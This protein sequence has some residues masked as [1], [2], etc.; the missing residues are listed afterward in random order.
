MVLCAGL[1][2][3][4]PQLQSCGTHSLRA[5]EE[6]QLHHGGTNGGKRLRRSAAAS[7]AARPDVGNVALLD[8]SDGVVVRRN[9]FNLDQTTLR[10]TPTA[11]GKYRYDAAATSYD[12]A[13]ATAGI[14]VD[15]LG[16][17]DSRETPLPFAF[18]FFGVQY[19]SVFVNSDGNL[20]FVTSDADATDR[21]LGRF[22]SGQPRIAP[23]FTD[24]DPTKS[25][26]GVRVLSEGGRFVVSWSAVPIFSDSGSAAP[27]TFQARLY[28]DGRIEFAYS[29]VNVA[30]AVVGISPGRLLGTPAFVSFTH[31]PS[32]EYS[33]A[34]V[35]R[36]AGSEQVDIFTAAQKFYQTHEDAYDY[37][38]FYNALG[39]RADQDV[40]AF[41]VTVRNNRK[42]Y[43][44]PP[45][46]LGFESGSKER[47]QAILNMGQ[48]TQ[49]P[50]DPAAR[51]PARATVGDTPVTTVAHEAGHLFLAYVSV[52]DERGNLPMLGYQSAH[53]AFTF[54]S[55]A[56]LLEGNRIQDNGTAANPRFL[57]TATVEGYAPLDQYLMGFRPPQEVPDTFYVANARGVPSGVPARVGVGFNGDRRNVSVGDVIAE[58]GR[59]TPDSTVAQRK[60]RFAFVLITAEGQQPTTT[61]LA[62]LEGY[63]TAFETFYAKAATNNAAAETQLT[64]ALHVS[65]FPAAGVA[66]G[67]TGRGMVS[68]ESAAAAPITVLLNS[69]TGGV[70]IARSVTIPAGATTASFDFAGVRQGVD[71]FSASVSDPGYATVTSRIQVAAPSDLRLQLVSG[72]AQPAVSGTML[73]QPVRVRVTDINE[74][75]YPNVTLS[76]AITGGGSIQSGPIITGI[77]GIAEIR[78]TPS[79]DPV[80]ELRLTLPSGAA[81][82][83]TA[84]GRPSFSGTSVVNAASFTPGLSAGGIA[85]IFGASLSGARV[86]INGRA[87]QVFFSNARQI[88]FY[89]PLDT[90]TTP[91]QVS[92]QTVAGTSDTI[93]VMVAGAQ[94]GIFF[95]SGSGYGAITVAGTGTVTQVRPGLRGEVL[96][97]YTTGLGSVTPDAVGLSRTTVVPQVT[98]S[99]RPAEVLFSGLAPGFTGLYQVNVRVPVDVLPGT[100]TLDPE[101]EWTAF[102]RRES[103]GAVTAIA[104]FWSAVL[105]LLVQ[106]ILTKAILPW[107]GGTAGVWTSSMLFYQCMLLGGYFYAHLLSTRFSL[108]RQAQIHLA[109]LLLS[110]LLLPLRPSDGW[111]PDGVADPLPQIL[112]LLFSTVGLPYFLLSATSPLVQ[113][114]YARLHDGRTPYRLFSVS[115]LGSL[116]ALLSY[117]VA[118]EPFLPTH[119]Q[120]RGWSI[121]YAVFLL[122]ISGLCL[123]AMRSTAPLDA[124][125]RS[126]PQH[127][128]LWFSLAAAP[129]VLWLALANHLSQDIAAVP[130]LWIL[131]LSIYLLSFILCFDSDRWYQPR[132]YRWLLPPCVI[133]LLFGVGLQQFLPFTGF[134]ALY[135]F[136]LFI[137]CMFCH[138]ELARRKPEPSGLT[139][140]Y[141]SMSAGGAFGG[142]FV[143]LIAPRIF[144][145]YLELPLAGLAVIVLS[146]GTLYS[147]SRS[148]VLRVGG[149]AAAA[150]VASFLVDGDAMD[151]QHNL[152]NFY[153]T[154]QVRQFGTLDDSKRTLNNGAIQHGAQFLMGERRHEPTTYYARNSGAGLTIEALRHPG[155]RVGV[156]GLGVG[157]L[158]AYAQKGDYYRFYEINPLVVH[159]AKADFGYLQDSPSM[160]D[161]ALGD[162]RL[163]LEREEPEN[164]DVLLIDAFSGDSIPIHLLTLQAI[165]LYF[166]HLQPNGALAV[167]ITNKHLDLEPVLRYSAAARGLFGFLI[168]NPRAEDKGIT[169]AD[170]VIL[171]RNPQL[172]ERLRPFALPLKPKY[173]QWTDDYSNLVRLLR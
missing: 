161:I 170:W 151:Q 51:V 160:P 2:H 24:L 86:T 120:L 140:F 167:H 53:W 20:T 76:T 1:L 95:D 101:R 132:I 64:R 66:V 111:K 110:A 12:E 91:A 17:D 26:S 114:W 35:E 15:K 139:A 157:T 67:S 134:L 162:A 41:E 104:V 77:D 57:T 94:P 166:R 109:L 138:G 10:F 136:E 130:F 32:N 71:E 165:D 171:T 141:L 48:L 154:L 172:L 42:G 124:Q 13:A 89:V 147:L 90:P 18:P 44:D 19:R 43:G 143:G 115:N 33:S 158:A 74:I 31:Q 126:W 121:G 23:L 60:F 133:G 145:I 119:L 11:G 73:A 125:S 129:S 127:A 84:L 3:A 27:Q 37:L 39:I 155:M 100:Q 29:G 112:G 70:Q 149:T 58:A 4:R 63:R 152:R 59:R 25:T 159:L 98:I 168:H 83:A 75:P 103:R 92:V 169:N 79:S 146:L 38:V 117:P 82:T 49:Y 122:A 45:V 106:P 164:F 65:T 46:D 105:L 108:K 144:N 107:F 62:Q 68:V 148:R 173:Q 40:V 72:D 14:V 69:Q 36:F 61:Q 113:S 52:K 150:V 85:T 97:V 80:N 153:G 16:D 5:S 9:P 93:A 88:N 55:E 78:W 81:V 21:S 123:R 28:P 102:Q 128:W 8:D 135:A 47:L 34:I 54:N 6:W 116:A 99:G 137:I 131:P 7:A 163:S 30:D 118:I 96:E 87:A 56:S 142:V 50:I 156:V 22:N